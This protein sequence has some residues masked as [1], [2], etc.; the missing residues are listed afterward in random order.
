MLI[1]IIFKNNT[2]IDKFSFLYANFRW[3][4]FKD[5][6]ASNIKS[7]SINYQKYVSIKKNLIINS[8][9]NRKTQNIFRKDTTEKKSA[10]RNDPFNLIRKINAYSKSTLMLWPENP[11]SYPN[12]F[13]GN[14]P[15]TGMW[16]IF[17]NSKPRQSC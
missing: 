2:E 9:L 17:Y 11:I 13:M 4:W 8:K 7:F 10:K 12:I 3:P 5:I 14:F 6:F 15:F 1:T 16:F